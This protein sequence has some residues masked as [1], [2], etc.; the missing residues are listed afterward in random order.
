MINKITNRNGFTLIEILASIVLLTVIISLFLSIFPQM[1]NMNHR[2]GENLDAANVSKE[3]LVSIKK[4]NYNQVS[5]GTSLPFAVVSVNPLEKDI[6]I[7]GKYKAFKIRLTLTIAEE[8]TDIGEVP[9]HQLKIEIFDKNQTV[10]IDN[11]ANVL[12]TTYGYIK[13]DK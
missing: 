12:S 7:I 1:G 4:N 3:L 11:K 13:N 6:I 2:N 9:L 8:E 5:L 10:L